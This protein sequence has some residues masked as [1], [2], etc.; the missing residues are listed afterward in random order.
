MLFQNSFNY[1]FMYTNYKFKIIL[2][3][4]DKLHEVCIAERFY[5]KS[6]KIQG[7]QTKKIKK[8]PMPFCFYKQVQFHKQHKYNT[9]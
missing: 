2:E 5:T 7:L 3:E 6:V 4:F 9:L 1:Q 8:V